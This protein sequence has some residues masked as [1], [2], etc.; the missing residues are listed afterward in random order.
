M[1]ALGHK[2]TCAVQEGMSA[3]H[4]IADMC[5]ATRDVRFV[6]IATYCAAVNSGVHSI[7]SSARTSRVCGTANSA[8]IHAALTPTSFRRLRN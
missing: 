8:G 5:A 7:T 3:L 4:P 6:P 2:R 1:S